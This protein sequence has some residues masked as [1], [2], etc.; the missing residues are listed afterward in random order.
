MRFKLDE[1]LPAEAGDRLRRPETAGEL[2]RRMQHAWQGHAT[3][4]AFI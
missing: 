3:I 1:N 4:D 2:R